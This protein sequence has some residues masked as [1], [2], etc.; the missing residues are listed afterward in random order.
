[1]RCPHCDVDRPVR[2]RMG[3]NYRL[4]GYCAHVVTLVRGS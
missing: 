2:K 3:A 1:M 4:L